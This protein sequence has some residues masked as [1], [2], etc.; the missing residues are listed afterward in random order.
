MPFII[1]RET[2]FS[3]A[4]WVIMCVFFFTHFTQKAR[5]CLKYQFPLYCFKFAQRAESG[6]YILL[7]TDKNFD[8]KAYPFLDGIVITE[9]MVRNNNWVPVEK[10]PY[11]H[12]IKGPS[13]VA[14][15]DS[16]QLNGYKFVAQNVIQEE[17]IMVTMMKK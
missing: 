9:A 13:I 6:P 2:F 1:L 5:K 12:V 17:F 4:I 3:S 15:M 10:R 11:T 8:T 7:M 14:L 16:F